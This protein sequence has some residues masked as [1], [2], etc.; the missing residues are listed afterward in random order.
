MAKMIHSMIRVLDE[1]RSVD[2]YGQAF[3][4]RVAQRLDFDSFTLV[5]LSNDETGFELELTI[6]KDR[7]APYDLGD[8]YGHLAV[9]VEDVDA[10][11]ARLTALGLAPRKLV[12]FAPGGEVIAR[13]FFVADPDGY[14][15]EVLQRRGRYL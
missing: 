6:N 4:L 2:F 13:F 3:G 12:D 14:Q 9:S 10:E 15:I 8:G 1:A 5:Y 11:H 7:E